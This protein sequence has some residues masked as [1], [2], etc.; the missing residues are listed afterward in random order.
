MGCPAARPPWPW[1][2]AGSSWSSTATTSSSSAPS[3]PRCWRTPAGAWTMPPSA[4]WGPWR[5]SG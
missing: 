5:S 2:S 4:S 3:R 1:W